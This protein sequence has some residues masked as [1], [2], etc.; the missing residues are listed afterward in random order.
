MLAVFYLLNDKSVIHILQQRP[1]WI[2]D[3][4]DGLGF[5]LLHEQICY[6]GIDRGTHGC[7]MDLFIILTLE[8]E[9]CVFVMG[10][11]EMSL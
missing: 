11:P 6:Y 5:K 9:A 3:S 4:T 2:V 7:A 1:G 8:K 10:S